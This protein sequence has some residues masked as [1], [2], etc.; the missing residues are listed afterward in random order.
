M[1]GSYGVRRN[2]RG[3]IRRCHGGLRLPTEPLGRLQSR[4]WDYLAGNASRFSAQK[5]DLTP[6]HTKAAR[7]SH[8]S[9][10]PL[11]PPPKQQIADQLARAFS[12][13]KGTVAVPTRHFGLALLAKEAGNPGAALPRRFSYWELLGAGGASS[14]GQTWA[15]KGRGEGASRAKL[16]HASTLGE[17]YATVPALDTRLGG[18]RR[19][20]FLGTTA[21]IQVASTPCA[22]AGKKSLIP[23]AF[24]PAVESLRA[25]TLIVGEPHLAFTQHRPF[26]RCGQNLGCSPFSASGLS[27]G[28]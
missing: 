15:F 4:R 13:G 22:A 25:G 20:R 19:C 9:L 24:P 27:F 7:A 3:R 11:R 1:W 10:P 18:R 21:V 26:P 5:A 2:I 23:H 12:L 16:S 17:R 14:T 8:L 6:I 28:Q